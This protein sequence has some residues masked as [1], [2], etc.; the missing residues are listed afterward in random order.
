M[1]LKGTYAGAV[2]ALGGETIF[3][4][5]DPQR[6]QL[7]FDASDTT[8]SR[9]HCSVRYDAERKCFILEN[10]SRN[11]TFLEGDRPLN[12]GDAA[13]L[14]SGDIFYLVTAAACSRSATRPRKNRMRRI[15]RCEIQAL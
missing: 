14:R 15:D 2:I 4:G 7:V 8:I 3:F 11:G 10:Y 5:R 9:V 12:D 13:D 1:G 6:C